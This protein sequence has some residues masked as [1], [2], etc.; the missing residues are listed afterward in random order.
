M[1]KKTLLL[2]AGA[3]VIGLSSFAGVTAIHAASST[4]NHDQSIVALLASKF[5]LKQADV[6]AVF[7]QEHQTEEASRQ[8]EAKTRLD[9]AVTAGKLTQ[10]QE[11]LITT[12]QT[13]VKTF[14]DS[15]EGETPS[16]RKAAIAKEMASLKEWATDNSIPEQ[17]VRML[18]GGHAGHGPMTAAAPSS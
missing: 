9:A 3:A 11:N 17:Y 16:E 10:A 2:T 15:L 4:A 12:K 7:D 13:E 5:N 8:A 6:Q 1:T 18:G 14:M